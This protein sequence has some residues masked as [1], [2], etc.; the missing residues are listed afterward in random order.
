MSN[1]NPKFTRMH[2]VMIAKAM[3]DSKQS[4]SAINALVELFKSDNDRFDE[5]RF[6]EACY[7]TGKAK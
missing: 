3:Y 5:K 7:E 2:Y 1:S 6:R 4:D